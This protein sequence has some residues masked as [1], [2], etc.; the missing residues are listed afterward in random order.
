[1]GCLVD[2]LLLL[3]A[4]APAAI[5]LWLFFTSDEYPEPPG[6]VFTTFILGVLTIPLLLSLDGLIY[7][8]LEALITSSNPYVVG[9]AK[10]FLLAAVPEELAKFA[11]LVG[12]SIRQKDFDEPMDGI[13]YGVSVSLGFAVLENVMYVFG[14]GFQT[15]LSRAV[16]AVPAHAMFGAIMGYY[17]GR[18]V[19]SKHL[20]KTLFAKA[21]L[22]PILLH[23]LYDVTPLVFRAAK[24]LDVSIP[25]PVSVALLIMF[26]F[27]VQLQVRVAARATGILKRKQQRRKGPRFVFVKMREAVKRKVSR[28]QYAPVVECTT[29]AETA[30]ELACV[31]APLS[32]IFAIVFVCSSAFCLVVLV[33]KVA[34]GMRWMLDLFLYGSLTVILGYYAKEYR[35]EYRSDRHAAAVKKK[36]AAS[37]MS[38]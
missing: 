34:M 21:L 19:F 16:T 25:F 26:V 27:V 30:G 15:A 31:P 17:A 9:T 20:K 24:Q 32:K 22:I 3:S 1:M 29:C 33:M 28:K 12:Y 37:G 10:A 18:A 38:E 2:Y 4:V 14:G 36:Q 23:G 13:V 35:D 5:L 6:V 11:V 7:D 8:P